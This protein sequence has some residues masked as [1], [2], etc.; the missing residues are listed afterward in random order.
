MQSIELSMHQASGDVSVEEAL[1]KRR[2]V[3]EYSRKPL[4]LGEV[5][6]LLWAGQGLTDPRGLR[7]APSAGALYPLEL[8]VA[9]RNVERV[10][11]G[12]YWY[13][14]LEHKL[15]RT[16]Q[17]DVR[18]ELTAAALWQAWIGEGAIVI[19]FGA[20]YQRTTVKY[21]ERG[22]RYVHIEVGHAAQNVFLQAVSLDLKAVV[23]GAFN[24]RRVQ[25]ILNMSEEELPL[26]LMPVGRG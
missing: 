16:V 10:P 20:V 19:A 6:Q 23:V 24:D 2:S 14:P 17:G 21:G 13:N 4:R 3:R 7:T 1:R 9:I 8:Y 11:S 18:D 5:S 26:L 15:I 25:R 22:I 12:V